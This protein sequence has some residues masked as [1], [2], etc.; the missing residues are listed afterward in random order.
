MKDIQ[1]IKEIQCIQCDSHPSSKGEAD[2]AW[3]HFGQDL[4]GLGV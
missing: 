4:R 1:G 2:P 3:R